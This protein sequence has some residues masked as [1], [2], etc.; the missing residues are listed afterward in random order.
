M[1]M[2]TDRDLWDWAQCALVSQ[3]LGVPIWWDEKTNCCK[4]GP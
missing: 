1:S 2:L 3:V 4:A